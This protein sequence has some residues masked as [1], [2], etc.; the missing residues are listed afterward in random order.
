M[1]KFSNKKILIL[2]VGTILIVFGLIFL[3][4]QILKPFNPTK[5]NLKYLEEIQ[6]NPPKD[7]FQKLK[8]VIEKNPDSYTRERAIFTLS[9][10]AI[11]KGETKEVVNYLKDVFK[12][13]K[14]ENLK[15]AILAN[16]NLL[17]IHSPQE[18]KGS[19]EVSLF[20]KLKK[21]EKV[22]LVAKVSSKVNVEKASLF[23]KKIH[24]N[25]ELLSPPFRYFS[26][27]ANEPKEFEFEMIFKETGEYEIP[28]ML[29][30]NFDQIDYEQIE[31]GVVINILK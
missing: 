25:I 12:K 21:N 17:K 31:E 3:K 1:K 22:I 16:L 23:L 11:E 14:N 9:D 6:K 28:V 18:K 20:G 30:L 15:S 27:N 2:G 10:I 4:F 24:K 5:V 8:S 7:Y 19:L 29:K 26:L 13:E